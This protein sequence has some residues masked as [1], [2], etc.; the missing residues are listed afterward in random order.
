MKKHNIGV[1]IVSCI[2]VISVIYIGYNFKWDDSGSEIIKPKQQAIDTLA[3]EQS[4]EEIANAMNNFSIDFY[5][6]L[7]I[8]NS[9]NMFF[10]P[11]SIFV[12]LSMVYE[13][14]RNET[15]DEM[16]NILKFQQYNETFLCSFGKIYNM[17]NEDQGYTANTANAI[18]IKKN[19]PL[20][21]EYLKLIMNYYMGE[22][23]ELNFSKPAKAAGIINQWVEDQTNGKIK[24]LIP[25]TGIN[26]LTRL[27]ITNAIYFKGTWDK[28]FNPDNTFDGD[29]EISPGNP[30]TV[31]MMSLTGEDTLFNYTETDDFQMIE[32]PY[33]G[34]D[35][36]MIIILPKEDKS[37]NS[38]EDSINNENFT[39]WK[40]SFYGT[41]V[42]IYL[43]KF[44]ME[45][46]YGLNEYLINMGM[47][48]AF[49]EHADFSG[50][51]GVKELFIHSVIH[52]AFIEVNEEGT[53]AAAATGIIVG[54][55][56]IEPTRIVFN[57]NHP[58]L[59]F[60]QQ[61]EADNILF[62]G[63]VSNPSE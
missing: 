46:E 60:I 35:I 4:V 1:I 23:T 58:F 47:L 17:L 48:N 28:Q 21:D 63:R 41:E 2:I 22:A 29:F 34:N 15:A 10:S 53:E 16:F 11:Y 44:K 59:F 6:S 55:S 7:S 51:N 31:P 62:M 26:A 56:S 24:D 36:S 8:D 33:T 52:K 50:I 3:T 19:Y 9:G 14:A 45:T 43:P 20:L 57:A 61:K 38:V 5:N 13:G 40:D 27:I 32:L 12:A 30:V 39:L 25:P 54:I 37:L 49:T 42:D 18:W